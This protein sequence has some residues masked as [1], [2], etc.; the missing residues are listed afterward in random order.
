MTPEDPPGPIVR[1]ELQHAA[2]RNGWRIEDGVDGG[3]VLRRSSSAP[4]RV[5]L[6]GAGPQGPWFLAVDHPGVAAELGEA[7][8]ELSGP[9]VARFALPDARALHAALG[10]VWEL[11]VALPDHPLRRFEAETAE[12]PRGTEAER[13]V[14]QRKGQDVFRESLLAY[15]GGR[16]PLT[17]ITDTA[18]LKASHMK[19]WADCA[20]DAER[21]D[22]YNG[23]LLS[24]LW[25]AAFDA[26]LVSFD[27]AGALLLSPHLTTTAQEALG[28]APQ[29]PLV[30]AHQP[31]LRWHRDRVFRRT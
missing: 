23:L 21:L 24:A 1:N 25:D 26:G 12:L 22:P 2:H 8:A 19:P 28:A 31:Y 15:W 14:V 13:L 27:D 5:G 7:A 20:T 29:L 4:G 10:R 3:W 6:A 9:G 30:P 16:C 17:G 11:A 18:L